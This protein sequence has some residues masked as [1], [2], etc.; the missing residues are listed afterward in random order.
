MVVKSQQD[1][2]EQVRGCFFGNLALELSAQDEVIRHKLQNIFQSW[3]EYFERVLVEADAA[4]D[5]PE[6]EPAA[7]AQTILAYF[8]GLALLAKV[9]ND[10]RT[11]ERLAQRTIHAAIIAASPPVQSIG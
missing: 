9:N 11:V 8:E 5:L 4:G 6:I 2:D 1:T 10:F 3:G 7:A